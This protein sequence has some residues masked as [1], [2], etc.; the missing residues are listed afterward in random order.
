MVVVTAVDFPASPEVGDRF[1]NPETGVWYEWD[2]VAWNVIDTGD[3]SGGGD[4]DL[5][6]DVEIGTD[7]KNTLTVHSTAKFECDLD[8]D[9]ELTVGGKPIAD[10]GADARGRDYSTV[11]VTIGEQL[12]WTSG[13]KPRPDDRGRAGWFFEVKNKGEHAYWTLW[14]QDPAAS[15]LVTLGDLESVGVL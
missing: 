5:S 9:G 15:S 10:G 6:G 14:S 4:V 8:V 2:G 12:A 1:Q 11:T 7:C 13:D 3:D